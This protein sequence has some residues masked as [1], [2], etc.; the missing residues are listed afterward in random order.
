MQ[1]YDVM[2]RYQNSKIVTAVRN[3]ATSQGQC[4]ES[5]YGAGLSVLNLS[6]SKVC[7][8]LHKNGLG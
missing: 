5:T 4:T 2:L 3:R 8:A 7:F 1:Y 6:E